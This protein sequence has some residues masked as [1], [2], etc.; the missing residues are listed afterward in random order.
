[1]RKSKFYFIL[2]CLLF[3][4]VAL[5]QQTITLKRLY[6]TGRFYDVENPVMIDP[7]NMKGK[8]FENKDILESFI[9]F[10]DQRS[11]IEELKPDLSD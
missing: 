7:V 8:K 4:Q 6:S 9:S 3:C 1:M 11:F 2:S 10:P 5:A